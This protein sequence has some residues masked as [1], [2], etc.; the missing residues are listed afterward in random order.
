MTWNE[1]STLIAAQLGRPF[2]TPLKLMLVDEAKLWRSRLLKDTLERNPQQ[3]LAGFEQTFYTAI[4]NNPDP[5]CI[6]DGA[7]CPSYRSVRTIPV[8]LRLHSG[9]FSY[10]GS[11]DGKRPYRLL[12]ATGH[13]LTGGKYAKAVRFYDYRGERIIL[14]HNP[15]VI[16]GRAVFDDPT[17][18]PVCDPVT[19]TV[20]DCDP[21]DKDIPLTGDVLQKCLEYLLA[22]KRGAAAKGEP[23]AQGA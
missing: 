1:F 17:K 10:L 22:S 9:L 6:P 4:E 15:R 12:G 16:M 8:P 23:D 11:V 14:T 3:S 20:I 2:D 7:L 18:V 5:E 13:Y 21:L 19:G